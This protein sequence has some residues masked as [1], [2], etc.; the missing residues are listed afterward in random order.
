MDTQAEWSWL[1]QRLSEIGYG[2]AGLREPLGVSMAD[3]I[4]LVN[5]PAVLARLAAQRSP[6]ATVLGLWFL[7]QK[8]TRRAL[9]ALFSR[10]EIE[11]LCA[12]ALV[13]ERDGEVRPLLR[14]DPVGELLIAADCRFGKMWRGALR[15]GGGDPVYPP[16]ADSLWLRDTVRRGDSASVLDLCTG[17]GIQALSTLG[18]GVSAVG[19]DVNGRAVR[20][21]RFNGALNGLD[22][23][24]FQCGDL[25][26]PVAA[27]KFDVII[28]N[29][30][31]VTSPYG[32]LGN[33]RLPGVAAASY[34]SGGAT[35]DVVLR[36]ILRAVPGHLRGDGRFFAVGHVGVRQGESMEDVAQ[37]W[38]AAFPG[39]AAVF[40]LET[41][42]AI[43]LAAAQ[44]LFA[45]QGGRRAHE[46][47]MTLWVGHLRHH[48]IEFVVAFLL[49]AQRGERRSVEVIDASPKILPLPMTPPAPEQVA[50]WLAR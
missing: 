3:E 11:Q 30:P 44:S 28:A 49:A 48:R 36:R 8:V 40:R 25:F 20:F 47:E 9:L 19:V 45:L 22:G 17:S 38:F 31:F 37:R 42:T 29:P 32:S 24:T 2:P 23:A 50:S 39:R 14:L 27:A 43:D 35:G 46:R 15:A 6:L 34:H 41:G 1:R 16:G 26:A 4:S 33:R 5:F 7:E 18:S 10:S 13:A 21:A 12:A